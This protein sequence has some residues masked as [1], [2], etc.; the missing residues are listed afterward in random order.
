MRSR[1]ARRL[2]LAVALVA[3]LLFAT[4][5]DNPVSP[6]AASVD[7]ESISRDDFFSDARAFA[8]LEGDPYL[9]ASDTAESF[10]GAGMASL[11]RDSIIGAMVDQSAARF[12]LTFDDADRAAAEADLGVYATLPER[13]R[14]FVLRQIAMQAKVL[15]Y[16]DTN[17]WWNDEDIERYAPLVGEVACVH[18]ILVDS[19]AAAEDVLAQLD[20]GADFAELAQS[21]STDTGSAEQ[22][23]DLG[24]QE[25][26]TFLPEFEESYADA[27]DG[28]IVGPVASEAGYHVILVET[29][30]HEPTAAEI[31]ERF[32]SGAS[33]WVD[34]VFRTSDVQVDR[35][36]GTWDP[37]AGTVNP[38]EGAQ[39]PAGAL[40]FEL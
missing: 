38:P 25:Q 40:N 39:A 17:Q 4:G 6:D 35:R 2:A 32:A 16:V 21:T 15:D 24:C 20:D 18:H 7:D 19:E 31:E 10:N 36:F 29:A 3:T 8:Q 9:L 5:C 26:G 37:V 11:L 23:G 28:D 14:E 22:G 27:E 33:G 12:G 30:F 1:I 34:F 13:Q